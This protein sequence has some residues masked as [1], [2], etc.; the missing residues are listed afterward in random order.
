MPS[1][2]ELHF[3]GYRLSGPHG[4]LRAGDEVVALPPKA[5]GVLWLLLSRAGEVVS[6]Q[7][8]LKVVWLGAV[9]TEG[10]IAACLRDLRR[11]LHDDAGQPRFI[12]TA[13]RIG[14]RFIAAVTRGHTAPAS[15][16][17]VD[18]RSLFVGR[19]TELEQLHSAFARALAGQR[20]LLFV[21][22]EA[23]IGKT[24]LVDAF[25]AA[26][27]RGRQFDAQRPLGTHTGGRLARGQCI[28]HYGAGEPYLPVLEALERLCRQPGA[29]ALLAK[30]RQIAPTALLQLPALVKEGEHLAL[31][32]K[33]A[34]SSAGRLLRELVDAVELAST[35][36]PLV[37]VLEDMHWS[38][39]ATVDWLAT[40]AR[41]REPA[42]LL[43][44]A[45]CRQVELIV[46]RHPLKAVKRELVSRRGAVELLLGPLPIDA[47]RTYVSRRI[48]GSDADWGN[49]VYRRS[50][51]HPLYMVHVA[52][53]LKEQWPLAATGSR[54]GDDAFAGSSSATAMEAALPDGLRELIEAQ[55]ARLGSTQQAALAAACVAG[56]EFAASSVAGALQ[57]APA[58]A[59]Q[60]LEGLARDAQFIE[61][62]GLCEWPD[63]NVSALYAF[64][65]ALHRETLYRGL[66]AARRVRLHA[67]IGEGLELSQGSHASEIAAELASHFERARKPLRAAC[68]YRAAA[69]T[70]LRR[71]ACAEA[72]A[73]VTRGL[74][75]LQRAKAGDDE[76]DEI[77]LL[78]RL[79]QGAAL[80]ATEG[81]AAGAVENTYLRAKALSQRRSASAALAP[82]LAGLWNVYLSR[83]S[84]D[85]AQHVAEECAELA[86]LRPDPTVAM[87]AHNMH[88]HVLLFSGD[89]AAAMQ[90]VE[91]SLELYDPHAHG[92]LVIEYGEDPGLVCHHGAALACWLLGEPQRVRRHLQQGMDIARA[93]GHPFGE[94]QMLWMDALLSFDAGDGERLAHI[95]DALLPLCEANGFALWLAG[96]RVLGGAALACQGHA[97]A[98]VAL[99]ERGIREWRALGTQLLVPHS[100]GVLASV[101]AADGRVADALGVLADALAE[102]THTGERWYE[103]ELH[104]LSAELT[105]LQA[106]SSL[107]EQ[108]LARR[109]YL[110][111]IA[112]AQ[113]QGAR[114]FELRATLGLARHCG[115][116]V[117]AERARSRLAAIRDRFPQGSE[118]RD[119]SEAASILG[120]QAESRYSAQA[121]SLR[122]RPSPTST[123]ALPGVRS[124]C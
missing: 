38:D 66:G 3:E 115:G 36:Q 99:T 48:A 110:R 81:F 106:G 120:P 51:G 58:V 2:D 47:V 31:Q 37:L 14:Y 118:T 82:V 22:G 52:G 94:A 97:E 70:A 71:H 85:A 39:R 54:E 112:V 95:T 12:A 9:V 124:A 32:L 19:E 77:E 50:E 116:G 56:A 86:H 1:A 102:A 62:R 49:A 114:T 26:I 73:H 100:L 83:A 57:W 34:G 67:S 11:A 28:E 33:V 44:I 80:L 109:G 72:L 35:E 92:T 68:H 10:V 107:R 7:E 55:I 69:Q 24:E 60:V 96:A 119:L 8:L 43:V 13:H 4:P 75:L 78:L 20:Q 98:G 90:H 84:F 5:L 40:L 15:E 53:S 41:R 23:G 46:R 25:T 16:G 63:G 117:N 121:C 30:L 93:L 74:S 65:H 79:T 105:A 123:A 18:A 104:R 113:R 108:R 87:L 64:R 88:V 17:S 42:R 111:A 89:P 6:K 29:D 61:A 45:T 21:T 91:R 122:G 27:A 103:A 101:L 76:C 59:E